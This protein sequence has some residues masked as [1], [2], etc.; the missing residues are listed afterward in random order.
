M[1]VSGFSYFSA[2]I[3]AP[4]ASWNT[5]KWKMDAREGV[6]KFRK[7]NSKR[8]FPRY[9]AI[10][11]QASLYDTVLLIRHSIAG[12]V[13]RE[14]FADYDCQP[15]NSIQR[16]PSRT[17]RR[18]QELELEYLYWKNNFLSQRIEQIKVYTCVKLFGK[19]HR[20]LITI[21]KCQRFDKWKVRN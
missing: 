3:N 1:L 10:A 17:Q 9:E 11:F 4:S 5:G 20:P 16:D 21:Y 15:N 8:W 13:I 12:W 14:Q 2:N 7:C 18:F 6:S 19:I